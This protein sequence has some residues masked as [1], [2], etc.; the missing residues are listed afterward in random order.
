MKTLELLLAATLSVC[1]CSVF[2]QWQW[3]DASGQKVYSD[4]PPPAHIAPPQI[5]KR[6]GS[7]APAAPSVRYPSA[8]GATAAP[9][10]TP[11]VVSE[12]ASETSTVQAAPETSAPDQDK[13]REAAQRKAEEDERKKHEARQTEVRRSNCQRARA[14]QA[15]LQSGALH[16][17]VNE[18]GERGLM[19]DAQRQ[20]ELQRAQ[21]AIKDN[22]R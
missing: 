4:R 8:E 14:M 13:A 22:C 2:A 17:Y 12:P 18:K 5:L 3:I 1:S 21:A 11:A 20:A 10:A 19:T 6:P 15:S 16:A 9:V 7:S